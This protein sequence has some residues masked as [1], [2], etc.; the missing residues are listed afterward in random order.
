MII[1]LLHH[2]QLCNRLWAFL[3]SLAYALHYKKRIWMLWAF[4]PYMDLFPQLK[5]SPYV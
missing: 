5:A 1:Y 3:P 2:E 4:K